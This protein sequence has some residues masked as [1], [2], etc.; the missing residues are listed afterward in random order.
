M[1]EPGGHVGAAILCVGARHLLARN[2]GLLKA[3]ANGVTDFWRRHPIVSLETGFAV[4]IG[5]VPHRPTAQPV[6]LRS[7][8]QAHPA[9]VLADLIH[10]PQLRHR[11]RAGQ[12]RHP[13]LTAAK[14]GFVGCALLSMEIAKLS[15]VVHSH[16]A[17][18]E[19]GIVRHDQSALAT[20][21]RFL[22][23]ETED[24]DIADRADAASAV[25]RTGTF[26]TIFQ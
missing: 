21:D 4:R 6:Q 1:R 7:Q 14:R 10:L 3:L 24:R 18:E 15:D 22:L 11:H 8:P 23:L 16:G 20:R 2:A 17:F 26:R 25:K 13:K 12:L 9:A 5:N 19:P